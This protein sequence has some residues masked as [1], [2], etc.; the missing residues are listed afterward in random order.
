MAFETAISLFKKDDVIILYHSYQNSKLGE[1]PTLLHPESIKYRYEELL[2]KHGIPDS[3]VQFHWEDRN[4][5]FTFLA[6]VGSFIESFFS[7]APE[8]P[9]QHGSTFHA[10]RALPRPPDFLLMGYTGLEGRRGLSLGSSS[11]LAVRCLH[12]PCI[13][14]KCYPPSARQFVMAV[15][16]SPNSKAGLDILLRLLRRS[17][18]LTLLHI[19]SP[20]FNPSPII[21]DD[22]EL[23]YIERQMLKADPSNESQQ[24]LSS[25]PT[26]KT[27][28]YY[29]AI[30][31]DYGPTHSVTM[32]LSL[33]SGED[34]ST[35]L[36]KAVN[37][38]PGVN[39]IAIAPRDSSDL[40]RATERAGDQTR[41]GDEEREFHGVTESMMNMVN[42][43]VVLC[44]NN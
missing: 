1:L 28:R 35:A 23:D 34:V 6:A 30:L 31:R 7:L 11:Q 32:E 24:E 20:L 12:I 21:D 41:A 36:A 8:H 25:S 5:G 42:C 27:R 18:H 40:L 44:R 17:D 14:C 37:H 13:I 16:S 26:H 9:H 43:S 10:V 4:E 33:Q 19:A 22:R 15:D 39:Y 2:F 3:Q 38:M 29:E